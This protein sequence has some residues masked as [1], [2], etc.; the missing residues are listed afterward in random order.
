MKKSRIA[1][2]CIS[3]VYLLA[4]IG[5]TDYGLTVY[6]DNLPQVELIP[7]VGARVPRECLQAGPTGTVVNVV[8]REDGPWGYRY[9]IRQLAVYSYQELPDGDLFVFEI[10]ENVNPIVS[11]S[12]AEY[13]YDGMEV[14]ISV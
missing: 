8:E 1:Y 12:T 14:R 9:V 2:I 11:G 13:L 4:A 5:A 3:I 6:Q 7:S 10:M